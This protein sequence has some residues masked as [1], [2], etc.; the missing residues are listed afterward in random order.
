MDLYEEIAKLAY[1]MFERE[2]MVHGKHLDHWF[3]AERIVISKY[4]EQEIMVEQKQEENKEAV[5]PKKRKPAVKKAK[6]AKEGEI[7]TKKS[8]TKKTETTKKRTKKT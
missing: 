1:E 4:K 6:E 8:T 3:E 7:K 2:G 5:A